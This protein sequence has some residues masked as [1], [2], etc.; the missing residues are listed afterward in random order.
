P[1]AARDGFGDGGRA[2][3]LPPSGARAAEAPT[4]GSPAALYRAGNYAILPTA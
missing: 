4:A 2:L 1:L 3:K